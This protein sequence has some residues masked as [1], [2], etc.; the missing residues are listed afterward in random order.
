M[1]AMRGGNGRPEEGGQP[2]RCSRPHDSDGSLGC[3]DHPASSPGAPIRRQTTP[4]V[5][6]GVD[7]R[8]QL[9]VPVG[10]GRGH[11]CPRPAPH[12]FSVQLV[13]RAVEM[14]AALNQIGVQ[15][16]R[17]PP[18]LVAP[19]QRLEQV[20]ASPAREEVGGHAANRGAR[21]RGDLCI[22]LQRVLSVAGATK[23]PSQTDECAGT[24]RRIRGAC[25]TAVYANG[26]GWRMLTELELLACGE[27]R[28]VRFATGL[29]AWIER[30]PPIRKRLHA[31]RVEDHT[32]D[33]T[34]TNGSSSECVRVA[35]RLLGRSDET[36]ELRD[37]KVG[38]LLTSLGQLIERQRTVLL[39]ESRKAMDWAQS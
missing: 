23:G 34:V 11:I 32:Y 35:Q 28:G 39:E 21:E 4:V 17:L 15:R 38:R 20:A 37:G 10:S 18:K 36:F 2:R 30:Q 26:R 25:Q 19:L 12:V 13:G 33:F 24:K 3:V 7:R 22:R 29:R 27:A 5:P 9:E 16:E 8:G 31:L 1:A 14:P 6:E